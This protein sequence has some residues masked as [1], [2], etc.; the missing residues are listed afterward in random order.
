MERNTDKIRALMEQERQTGEK[1]WAM[2][3]PLPKHLVLEE[4]A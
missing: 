1:L 4:I 3:L 2:V